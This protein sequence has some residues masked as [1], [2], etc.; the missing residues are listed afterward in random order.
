MVIHISIMFTY[1]LILFENSSLV[2]DTHT[3]II[4]CIGTTTRKTQVM[5]I[6]NHIVIQN[7][8]SPIHIRIKIRIETG[9]EQLDFR[10][11]INRILTSD[12]TCFISKVCI[13]HCIYILRH[14]GRIG[15]CG[16]CLEV[17]S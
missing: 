2:H 10:I 5:L 17:N 12:N 15:I 6:V 7:H 1:R 4:T 16:I 8:I 14:A 3:Y 11:S 9:T 13:A